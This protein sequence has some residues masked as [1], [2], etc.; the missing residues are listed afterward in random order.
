MHEKRI[1]VRWRDMDG[2]RHVN[3]AV[4]LTY[5]EECRDEFMA[6]VLDGVGELDDFVLAHVEIDYRRQLTQDDD[7]VVVRCA[8][9]R[10]GRSSVRTREEIR[11]AAG[12]L[13]ADAAS[14]MVPLAPGGSGARALSDAE[15]A[16]YL[17]HLPE[18]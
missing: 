4:F 8:L 15:R 3:N 18:G 16:A 17:S 14:V 1:E 12:E 6:S 13:A 9:E 5:L 2:F 7:V 10:I 11:T